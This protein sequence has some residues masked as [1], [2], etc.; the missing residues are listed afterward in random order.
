MEEGYGKRRVR[1][2]ELREG[3]GFDYQRKG[4]EGLCMGKSNLRRGGSEKGYLPTYL[5]F[6]SHLCFAIEVMPT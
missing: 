4:R 2:S 6:I 1:D 3:L 5:L